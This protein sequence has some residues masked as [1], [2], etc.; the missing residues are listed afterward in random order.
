MSSIALLKRSIIGYSIILILL[1]LVAQTTTT[2]V[3]DYKVY[4]LGWGDNLRVNLEGRYV[5]IDGTLLDL[6]EPLMDLDT[7]SD[8]VITVYDGSGH[9]IKVVY[10]KT[11]TLSEKTKIETSAGDTAEYSKYEIV[12]IGNNFVAVGAR[13]YYHNVNLSNAT[14]TV[15]WSDVTDNLGGPLIIVLSGSEI[16][17]PRLVIPDYNQTDVGLIESLGSLWFLFGLV[18]PGFFIF[19]N[20]LSAAI[21]TIWT[22]IQFVFTYV[23]LGID[24][25]QRYVIPYLG[26]F[27]GLYFFGTLAMAVSSIPK[28]GLNALIDWG[29]LWYNHVMALVR[30]IKMLADMFIKALQALANIISSILPL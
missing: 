19:V 3:S 29:K 13:K 25:A 18:V 7:S 4:R 30:F 27:I 26:M 6:R 28:Q 12:A 1:L 8:L 16:G 2:T 15:D 9:Y 17:D 20:I 21:T 14:L 23:A 5:T 24:I 10:S 11:L 22:I